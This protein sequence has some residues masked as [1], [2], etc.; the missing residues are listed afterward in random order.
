MAIAALDLGARRIGIA[1]TDA[2]GLSAHPLRTIERRSFA[3][4]L[5]AIR[6]ALGSRSIDCLVVGLPVNMNGT[7]GPMARHARNF[8]AKLAEAWGIDVKLQDERLSSFEA[9]GRL[10]NSV[11]HGKKKAAIDAVAAVVI[12]EN[13]LELHAS[14]PCKN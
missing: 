12:L 14:G 2:H 11:P 7:E 10:A 1:V 4:D 3:A 8:A 13:Y 6:Q 9:E 5:E